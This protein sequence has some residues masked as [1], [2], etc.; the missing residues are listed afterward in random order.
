L[1]SETSSTKDTGGDKLTA[2]NPLKRQ[3]PSAASG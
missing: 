1:H 2:K 3:L